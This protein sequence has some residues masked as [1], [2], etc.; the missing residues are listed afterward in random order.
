LDALAKLT[1]KQ[2]APIIDMAARGKKVSAK[3]V[4]KRLAREA[5]EIALGAKQVTA[6][7]TDQ[8]FGVIYADPPW[9][10]E[11]Y[12]RDTGLDRAAD[13]H[14]PTVPLDV[15]KGMVIPAANDCVLFL[16]ATAPMMV[17]ALLL[18]A[19][20]GF[21]Y[22]SQCVWVKDRIGTG[23]W[24]RNQ[25]ELLLV[26]T[27]GETPAPAPGQ[28]YS[29]VIEAPVGAHSAKPAEFADKI[30]AMFPHLPKLEMFA[31]VDRPGWVIWG[32]E[33]A[34]TPYSEGMQ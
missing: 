8:R 2:Q 27:R 31:R 34:G 12:S 20:W 15:L 30:A 19:A 4:A 9:R 21:D 1:P 22:K 32:N 14:Y 11:P 33:V 16:W 25:H 10:F 26:G 6:L 17:E 23:Y 7:P 5:K 29:S 3:P 13:N 28:Q 24:F 18:M